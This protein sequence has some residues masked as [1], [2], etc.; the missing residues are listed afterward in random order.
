MEPAAAHESG[1]LA[2]KESE[3]TEDQ[4]KFR[5]AED[6]IAYTEGLPHERRYG[7]ICYV[8]ENLTS[9]YEGV[10]IGIEKIFEYAKEKKIYLGQVTE[11][12]FRLSWAGIP[13]VIKLN[14][15]NRDTRKEVMNYIQDRWLDQ[16]AQ[17]WLAQPD[18]SISLLK[19]VQKASRTMSFRVAVGKVNAAAI[20]R[21]GTPRRGISAARRY[22]TGDWVDALKDQGG[23]EPVGAE[24]LRRAG[25]GIGRFGLVCPA[26]EAL[27]VGEDAMECDSPRATGEGDFR[28]PQ[29]I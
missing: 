9:L 5:S 1:Q 13:D 22:V 4:L 16:E 20:R 8:L 2:L 12:E 26:S 3:S 23:S 17:E 25:M 24:E 7:A 21:V 19:A 27:H 6:I 11:E 28:G 10:G 15:K 18:L 29:F 14:K